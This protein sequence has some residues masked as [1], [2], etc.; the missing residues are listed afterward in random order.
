MTAL[1]KPMTII[2]MNA[3]SVLFCSVPIGVPGP[4]YRDKTKDYRQPRLGI[5]AVRDYL[6]RA[7]HPSTSVTFFDIELLNPTDDELYLLFQENR[8]DIIGLGAVLSHSYQQ[9]KRISRIAREALPN[10]WIVVGGHLTASS[11]VL[12][13]KTDTDI[14]I[15]GDGEEPFYFFTRYVQEVGGKKDVEALSKIPGLCFLGNNGETVFDSYAKKPANEVISMPDYEFFRR[16]LLDKPELLGRYFQKVEEKGNWFALD[17]RAKEVDRRPNSAQVPTTKGCTARCTFCQRSTKGYRLANLSDLENHLIEIIEKYEVGFISVLDENFGSRRDHARAFAD[18]MEKHNL[19]WNASGVRCTNVSREDVE[20]FKQRGCCSLK[21][22]VESGSQAILDMMEKNFTIV[23]VENALTACWDNELYSPLAMMVGMPG[24][25][26]DTIIETGQWVGKMAHRL[27]IEPDRMGYEIFYALPFP[28]TPLYEYCVQAGLI[29]S[30]VDA[31]EQYLIEMGAAST[32]KWCYLNVNGASPASVLSWDYLLQWQATKTY[33][34]MLKN[35]PLQ[36]SKFAEKWRKG[37]RSKSQSASKR[38][39]KV[40]GGVFTR[41]GIVKLCEKLYRSNAML[42]LPR[43][44]AFPVIKLS[45]FVA[46]YAYHWLGRLTG[47]KSTVFMMYKDRRKPIK[48]V[49]PDN[50]EKRLMRSL[51]GQNGT[52]RYYLG[53]IQSRL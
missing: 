48:Y 19:L 8:A 24:E 30:D 10:A 33:R 4:A 29:G 43:W 35:K 2:P 11:S 31:E 52:R 51:R 20:Y 5:Q 23:D 9:V 21:F 49:R 36:A 15:V 22:G 13:R 3:A 26:N 53:L 38:K 14:C 28:G 25:G 46:I 1:S 42:M 7:G 18:L 12:L 40:S 39:W 50:S 37:H 47:R 32:T 6:I 45:F 44:L 17:P 34:S 27:G 16:G 41:F